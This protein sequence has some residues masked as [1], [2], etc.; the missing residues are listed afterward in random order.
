MN[1]LRA[2]ASSRPTKGPNSQFSL[3]SLG[4][5]I[6]NNQAVLAVVWQPSKRTNTCSCRFRPRRV[7]SYEHMFCSSRKS[8]GSQRLVRGLQLVRSFLLLE[9]DYEVD[10]EVDQDEWLGSPGALED[11]DRQRGSVG[12][13][14]P[15]RTALPNRRLG[16]RRPGTVASPEQICLCPVGGRAR[17]GVSRGSF[18]PEIACAD[19]PRGVGSSRN[20]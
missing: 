16:R 8:A 1:G 10:W 4:A 15:H 5:R 2:Y 12:G 13:V 19:I 20:P 17:A 9:D 18:S 11:S 14:H 7:L 6:L 3:Q